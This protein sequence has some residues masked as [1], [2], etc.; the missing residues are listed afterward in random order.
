MSRSADELLYDSEAALR[1]VDTA[2]HELNG[3]TAEPDPEASGSTPETEEH[4]TGDPNGIM[5]LL[6]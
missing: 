5:N 4:P 6:S 1:L 3:A 2:L